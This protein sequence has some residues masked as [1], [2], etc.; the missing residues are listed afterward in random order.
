MTRRSPSQAVPRFQRFC[1]TRRSCRKNRYK[2]GF[3]RGRLDSRFCVLPLFR[4]CITF[5]FHNN[6]PHIIKC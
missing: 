3:E 5:V 2:S 4:F 1:K 6:I